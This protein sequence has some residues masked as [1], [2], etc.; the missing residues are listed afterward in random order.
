[1]TAVAVTAVFAI[2]AIAVF[3]AIAVILPG[4]Q[5]IHGDLIQN[6][7]EDGGAGELHL[8]F[9]RRQGPA[10]GFGVFERVSVR[11]CFTSRLLMSWLLAAKTVYG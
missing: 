2:A 4:A 3:A 8:L 9:C 5:S 6:A 11:P 10:M 1:M 7:A